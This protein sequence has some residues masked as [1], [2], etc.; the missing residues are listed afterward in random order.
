MF[1]QSMHSNVFASLLCRSARLGV[2]P[3]LKTDQNV[4]QRLIADELMSARPFHNLVP[5]AMILDTSPAQRDAQLMTSGPP[6]VTRM[7]RA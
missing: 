6:I 5:V 4:S 3:K 7:E 1:T 2:P